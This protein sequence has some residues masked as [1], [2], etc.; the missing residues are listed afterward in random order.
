MSSDKINVTGLQQWAPLC[1]CSERG[2]KYRPCTTCVSAT[3][4]VI[5][6]SQQPAITYLYII[7]LLVFSYIG[8]GLCLQRSTNC[9]TAKAGM[10]RP[11]SAE[12]QVKFQVN[13]CDIC[14]G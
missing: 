7:N 14:G 6:F 10:G 9:V 4:C 3:P 13:T 12:V 2:N 5:S 11:F 8:D 1:A